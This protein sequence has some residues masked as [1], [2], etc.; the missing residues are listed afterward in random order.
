MEKQLKKNLLILIIMNSAL[1]L[2]ALIYT[3]TVSLLSENEG[4]SICFI[5]RNLHIYC[6]GCGGSRSLLAFLKFDLLSSFVLYPPIIISALVILDY[7]RR[8]LITLIRKDPSKTASFK[9]YTFLIIPASIIL[10]FIIRN[11]L[12]IC[13]KIDTVGDFSRI[14]FNFS[15]NNILK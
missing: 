7:D 14:I 13:F 2:F 15:S 6:P 11:I 10:T 4:E 1:I 3:L 9:F 12:L 5:Q 8:L